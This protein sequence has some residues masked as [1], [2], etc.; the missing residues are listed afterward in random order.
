MGFLS[1]EATKSSAFISCTLRSS[2]EASLH[3]N[4]NTRLD[5]ERAV[6]AVDDVNAG[7]AKSYLMSEPF[8]NCGR[9]VAA[10]PVDGD[11][12]CVCC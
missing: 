4:K 3:E 12:C 10:A 9:V 6:G 5:G 11:V 2:P 8:Q 1:A 7:G